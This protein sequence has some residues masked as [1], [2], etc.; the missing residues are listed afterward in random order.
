MDIEIMEMQKYYEYRSKIR[1]LYDREPYCKNDLCC[2]LFEIRDKNKCIESVSIS[3]G[4]YYI[5]VEFAENTT[6]DEMIKHTDSIL[7]RIGYFLSS[8]LDDIPNLSEEDK[9][10]IQ[11]LITS[12]N[13][14]YCDHMLIGNML[15]INL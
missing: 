6:L 12:S 2:S 7:K 15:K 5:E 4:D 11:F 14:T 10:H 8:N 3:L 9:D 13:H 1:K